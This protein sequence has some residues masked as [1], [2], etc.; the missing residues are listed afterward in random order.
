HRSSESNA[1]SPKMASGLAAHG[2]LSFLSGISVAITGFGCDTARELLSE[3][4]GFTEAYKASSAINMGL[5]AALVTGVQALLQRRQ[6]NGGL[7]LNTLPLTFI[8]VVLSLN[9]F[10]ASALEALAPAVGACLLG[11]SLAK[12]WMELADCRQKASVRDSDDD[13]GGSNS[14]KWT[15]I[16]SVASLMGGLLSGRCPP[17][18]PAFMVVLLVA[19]VGGGG[20]GGGGSALAVGGGEWRATAALVTFSS[21]LL[22]VG[23]LLLENGASVG[24]LPEV[25]A[26]VLGGLVGLGAGN[27]S[28]RLL[29]LPRRRNDKRNPVSAINMDPDD[30]WF[31]TPSPATLR[32]SVLA[33]AL[34]SSIVLAAGGPPAALRES[35]LSPLLVEAALGT[36]LLVAAIGGLWGCWA[37]PATTSGAR[38]AY[39]KVASDDREAHEVELRP[40]VGGGS[41][42][43]S[44]GGG[45]SGGRGGGGT[46]EE[47]EGYWEG[48][49][50]RGDGDYLDEEDGYLADEGETER[51]GSIAGKRSGTGEAPRRGAR[52]AFS[53]LPPARN[54][55]APSP[56]RP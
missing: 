38:E 25:S 49:D 1:R 48:G 39:G 34:A 56:A 22:R 36:V 4:N 52:V 13:Q 19:G 14:W 42:S 45:G 16:M 35:G 9:V 31:D 15:G 30:R 46:D 10:S 32:R 23:L 53:T 47:D 50:R 27:L 29:C 8:G 17:P 40:F 12:L 44:D 43:G 33:V 37:G 2:V 55:Y 28:V 21:S 41:G 7:L 54:S 6:I 24:P 5:S 51:D 20:G 18:G 11:L 26:L 3:I